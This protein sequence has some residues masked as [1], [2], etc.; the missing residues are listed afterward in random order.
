[1]ASEFTA[2]A[3]QTV[4]PN[5][6]VLFTDATVPCRRGFVNHRSGSGIFTLQSIYS[7]Y[8]RTG[9]NNGC[10]CGCNCNNRDTEYLVSFGA[11]VAIP[12]GGTVESISLALAIN[13]EVLPDSIMTV[14]PAAVEEFTNINRTIHIPVPFV[15]GCEEVAVKNISTQDI[16]V[17]NASI[18]FQIP[19]LNV[20]R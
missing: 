16:L 13:G 18:V 11:N 2:I 1:M 8:V 19:Q 3:Q 9:C 4:S 12:T 10:S 6:N 17:Q 7:P 20:T 14:T 5:Q 15:C